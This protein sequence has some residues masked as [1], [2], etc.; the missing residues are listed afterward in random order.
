MRWEYVPRE[1]TKDYANGRCSI[2]FKS[3]FNPLELML[4]IKSLRG[5]KLDIGKDGIRSL[6]LEDYSFSTF[7]NEGIGEMLKS[8][9]EVRTQNVGV[10]TQF[11]KDKKEEIL[12]S[13]VWYY[14]SLFQRE[15]ELV[16]IPKLYLPKK[17]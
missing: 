2:Y 12:G 13:R 3:P 7:W 6:V 5:H 10:F 4:N 1:E 8:L 9:D 14:K 16:E 15:P 17:R 11:L